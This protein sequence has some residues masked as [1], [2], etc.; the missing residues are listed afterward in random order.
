MAP[1]PTGCDGSRLAERYLRAFVLGIPIVYA[2]LLALAWGRV[3]TRDLDQF[4]VFHEL[5]SWNHQLFGLAKQWTP[6][7]CS[8]LSLADEPQ[9]PFMS[10]SMMLGYVFGPLAGLDLALLIYLGWGWIGAYLY[11]G[12]CS[13]ESGQRLLAASLFIG[14]GFFVCRIGY[15]HIDFVPF[16]TLPFMLWLLHRICERPSNGST[17]HHWQRLIALLALAASMSVAV[18]GSPVA[19]LHLLFWIV[20]YALVLSV[21]TRSAAPILTVVLAGALVALLDAGYLW[22]MISAQFEF[23]RRTADSF[24]NPLSLAWFALLP[25][26]GK[27]IIPAA[28]NGHELSIFIGPVIAIALW[29]YRTLV[30]QGLPRNLR[31]P[32]IVVSLISVWMGMGSLH[33]LHVPVA[34]SPFDWL[35]PLP[36]FHSMGVTGRYWGF[37]ALPLSLLGAAAL[38]RFAFQ[39]PNARVLRTWM[40]AALLLQFGFQVDVLADEAFAGQRRPPIA[41]RPESAGDGASVRYVYGRR[42][43]QGTLIAPRQ[44]VIDCYDNDDFTHARMRAGPGLVQSISVDNPRQPPALTAHFADWDHIRIDAASPPHGDYGSRVVIAFNQAYHR[45][46]KSSDCAVLP[47]SSGNMVAVCDGAAL[48][49]HPLD[50]RFHDALSTLG[51]RVSLATWGAWLGAMLV[52]LA[53]SYAAVKQRDLPC[54]D[55]PC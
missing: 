24:T 30:L 52:L 49:R 21:T 50:I 14:N 44:G 4:L 42:Q 23:P 12:L 15:G 32:L 26:R 36:A 39:Q 43:L 8:G 7:L 53:V 9:V 48:A 27:L 41:A 10:L 5:Q 55:N 13:T 18:D 37:L 47:A 1:A 20:C 11:A 54:S 22:P 45:F 40:L 51:A 25:V 38:R 3:G 28:G 19:I 16:L 33:V 17:Q 31:A 29:R 46:W 6:V 2:I 35:R 34:L